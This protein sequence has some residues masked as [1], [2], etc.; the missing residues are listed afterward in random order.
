MS[1][2]AEGSPFAVSGDV[3]SCIARLSEDGR[4]PAL[5]LA[6]AAD[7]QDVLLLSDRIGAAVPGTTVVACSS[8]GG[9]A[10]GGPR[11]EGVVLVVFP[12]AGFRAGT[13]W[14]SELARHATLD[15]MGALRELS[16]AIPEE[17]GRSRFGLL[18]VDGL[19]GRE[20]LVAAVVDSTLPGLL[21]LGGSTA[22]GL[23]FTETA[24]ALNSESRGGSAV[25]C[26]L[27]TPFEVEEVVFDHFTPEGVPMVVTDALPEERLLLTI[28]GEP[29]AEEYAVRTGH[30]LEELGPAVF[31][32]HPLMVRIG[33]RNFVRAIRSVTPE[34]GLKLMSL[35]ETGTVLMLGHAVS[36]TEG[37]ED[38]LSRLSRPVD[39]V[40]GFDCILRRIA[41]D[42]SELFDADR[43]F[44]TFRVAGFNTYGEQHGGI[45]VNQ[46]FVGLAFLG[47]G[48][49]DVSGE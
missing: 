17:P 43:I 27:S 38:R 45:H 12:T 2:A 28:N 8:A 6:F 14:L 48:G 31:A 16:A 22:D 23:R 39:M 24:L 35:L 20:E 37:L 1:P 40:L 19:S 46:T 29:A 7:R 44:R 15:W 36:P 11:D 30:R 49:P 42:S 26:L 10:Y 21:V 25:F 18:L 41:L 5:V 47:G 9:F 33:G 4:R 3:E 32:R 13:I 34:G